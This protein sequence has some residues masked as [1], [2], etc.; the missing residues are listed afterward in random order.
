L[1]AGTD[2]YITGGKSHESEIKLAKYLIKTLKTGDTFIDVGAH[3][4]YFSLLASIMVDEEGCVISFEP[5]PKS[6]AILK[7]NAISKKNIIIHN[8][9]VSDQ[10]EIINFYEFPNRYSEYNSADVTQYE[11]LPWYKN[12]LPKCMQIETV[13][14]SEYI[15]TQNIN[16]HII[17]IDVEGSEL[18]VIYGL[19]DY[20]NQSSP[21][22]IMEFLSDGRINEPHKLAENF[23]RSIQYH[24][25]IIRSDGEILKITDIAHYMA[26]KNCD[27]ENIVFKRTNN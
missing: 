8:H 13:I 17:K 27:S 9:A 26:E 6:Y 25:Y 18:K 21:I 19:K 3:F 20:L 2:I 1:P 12:N 4:G 5:S 7:K 22:I 14:L 11:K 10:K 23:L 16:P 15:K 24:S